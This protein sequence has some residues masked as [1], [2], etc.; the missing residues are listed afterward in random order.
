MGTGGRIALA[1]KK[2]KLDEDFL[3]TYGDGLANININNLI[4]FHY[5]KNALLTV[6]AVRPKERYGIL[7]FDPDTH[8]VVQ[9][10]ETK[11]KSKIYINGGY[12]IFSKKIISYIK[13]KNVY[14]EQGPLKTIIKK[15]KL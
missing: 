5:N 11:K 1:Y 4:N 12:F 14:F 6:T 15:K 3:V 13:K 7:K 9:L 2:L 10:D 8:R